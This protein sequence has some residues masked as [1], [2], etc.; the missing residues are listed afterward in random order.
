VLCNRFITGKKHECF[1]PYCKNCDQNKEVGHFCYIK[2]L[3][4]ELPRNDDAL[5]VFYDFETT[6]DTK[7]SDKTNVHSPMLV[8]LQQ[9][10]TA[11]EMQ[12]DIHEN[13]ERCCR[14]RHSF[15][16]DPL[17]DLLSYLCEPRPWCK[18]VVAIAHNAK[19]FDS[20]FILNRAIFLKWNPEIILSGQNIISMRTQHL[21]FLDSV[22]LAHALT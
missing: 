6:Q 8:C 1:K 4:N 22:L 21:H 7:V 3:K 14:R 15:F 17:R 9:F 19:A 12:D 11:C 10:C 16:E 2:P 20:Q 18:K 5:F 13:C